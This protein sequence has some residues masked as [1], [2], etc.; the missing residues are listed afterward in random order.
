MTTY[1]TDDGMWGLTARLD[2]IM[3]A[4]VQAALDRGADRRWRDQHKDKTGTKATL[5]RAL[6]AQLMADALADVA[7]CSSGNGSNGTNGGDTAVAE[8]LT[9]IILI[10]HSRLQQSAQGRCE[11]I[12]GTPVPITT[13]QRIL[14]DN[15]TRTAVV[16]N[17]G[18]VLHLGRRT[19][20]A[21]PT[22]RT[23]LAIR[24]KG[25]IWPNCDT[26]PHWCH[27]HHLL[28]W[29]HHGPTNR[30]NLALVCTKHHHQL[31]EGHWTITR[32]PDGT[33][34][35]RPPPRPAPDATK[36]LSE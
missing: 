4:Q 31:H 28:P 14:C 34:Q 10:D 21:T 6:R 5:G 30:D 7:H 19:R 26:N 25:C 15:D 13:A 29:Q 20:L 1:E 12:D 36:D 23:A 16:D 3:G 24:D 27:A 32:N 33:W 17:T 8:H 22:Q 11:L 18:D 9:P 35:P 2:P